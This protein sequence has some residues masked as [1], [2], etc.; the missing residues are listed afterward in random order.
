MPITDPGYPPREGELCPGATG[1]AATIRCRGHDSVLSPVKRAGAGL[2]LIVS[3]RLLSRVVVTGLVAGVIGATPVIASEPVVVAVWSGV[4]PGSEGKS[5]E[6]TMRV[7]EQGDHVVSNVH[8][9]SLTVYP[10]AL[11]RATGAAV[12]V[13]PG[14]GHRELWMDH[15]G[16]NVAQ[17]LSERGIAAFVLKYRLARQEGSTYTIEGHALAD[18]QRALRL[19]RHRAVEWGVDPAR[20]GVMGFSAG[21]QVAALAAMR[22]DDGEGK[23]T[24]PVSREGSRPAF[25]ILVYPGNSAGIMPA[26]GAPPAFLLCGENDRPDIAQGLAQAYL[27]FREAGVSAELH[28]YAGVGHGFGLR[29]TN[30][31][32]VAGWLDRVHDWL[33]DRGM[34]PPRP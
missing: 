23:S 8:R 27:R 25:Q 7:T 33:G 4:A 11:A 24:D 1:R 26:Q 30:T 15:E 21:G 32:A 2:R 29:A 17:W 19:I 22:G 13:I 18:A 6:E 12:L 14:G 20:L 10:A 34:L 5:G 31:G 16:Y 3:M 28:I 9:P